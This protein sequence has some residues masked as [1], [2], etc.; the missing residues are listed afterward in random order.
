MTEPR[1]KKASRKKVT[2]AC[3]SCRKRKVKCNI[4]DTFPCTACS[5]LEIECVKSTIDKRKER[6]EL[7]YVRKL[8]SRLKMYQEENLRISGQLE[9]IANV[10]KELSKLNESFSVMPNTWPADAD[11]T[12]NFGKTVTTSHNSTEITESPEGCSN[13]INSV[14][15]WRSLGEE[16][17]LIDKYPAP[18][19]FKAFDD[20]NL[21]VYGPTSI[22]DSMS[23]SKLSDNKGIGETYMLNS[24]SRI[25]H[26]VKLFF[27]WQY[28]DIH[29]F[30]FREAFLLDFFHAKINSSYCSKE[31]IFAICSFG[32]LLS[33]DPSRKNVSFQFYQKAKELC[34]CNYQKPSISLLQSFLLLGLYDIYN[35]RN[36]SGWLLSGIAMR[37]GYSIGLQL[38]PK[39][40]M[41]DDTKSALGTKIRSRIFWG[42]YLVDHLI[43]LLLGR[44][45]S[46]KMN[47]STIEETIELPNID[48]IHDYSFQG[49]NKNKNKILRIG[50]PLR[51]SVDLMNIAEKMLN[52]IFNDRPSEGSTKNFEFYEKLHL[53][54]KY[55]L[56][57]ME[58][59][60]GLPSDLLWNKADLEKLGRDPTNLT[61][62]L[63]YYIVL[64]CLNR[65]FLGDKKRK[66]ST[67]Y[68]KSL[69]HICSDAINEL[70]IAIREFILMYGFGK[71]S[72][73]IIYCCVISIS[74][75]LRSAANAPSKSFMKDKVSKY[76]LLLFLMTLKN[77]SS[78]WGL[79]QKAYQ[80][81]KERLAQEYNLSVELELNKFDLFQD[82]DFL[83]DTEAEH[84]LYFEDEEHDSNNFF[85]TVTEC[86]SMFNYMVSNEDSLGGPPIFMTSNPFS[87]TKGLFADN[88]I[89]LFD[90]E[91]KN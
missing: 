56:M 42:T 16:A 52:D 66:D 24:N 80:L 65:P 23:L 47:D 13:F 49:D 22:F 1:F 6:A 60:K 19:S 77:C 18:V 10:M 53:V 34:F 44:P 25:V 39:D 73:L 29:I 27:T 82:V 2:L 70:S 78:V 43:S 57:I 50:D 91:L 75:I 69:L 12:K 90:Y 37:M 7:E 8:E 3:K 79:S 30:I 36:D 88:S 28:P 45:S 21:S 85:E 74:V 54:K 14:E 72:M 26:Y 38:D 58:W 81:T 5:S 33:D 71:C 46:L 9:N 59:R 87:N 89:N 61:F 84:F 35:G 17:K 41:S 55:N 20:K 48:W 32:C 76:Q 31:L 51:A 62:K 68:Q 67:K 4:S 86:D 64:L 63:L 11:D 15:T 40:W 83:P